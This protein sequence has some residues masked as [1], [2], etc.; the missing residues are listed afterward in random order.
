MPLMQSFQ[1]LAL[2]LLAGFTILAIPSFIQPPSAQQN[3]PTRAIILTEP[4]RPTSQVRSDRRVALVIGNSN[5][6]SISRLQNPLNDARDMTEVLGNLGFDRVISVYD[7]D[8]ESMFEAAATFHQELK[9]GSVGV[10]FYAGHGVQSDGENYLI[11]VD[12]N[13]QQELQLRTRTFPVSEI[14]NYIADA[15]NDVNIVILDAC[16]DNPFRSWGRSVS[17]GLAF[18]N[19]PKGVIIAYATAPGS[20]AADGNGNNGTY[21]A[22]LLKHIR[23]PDLSI[24]EL[25]KTVRGEVQNKTRNLQTPWESTSLTGS[26]S[27]NPS[28]ETIAVN[29]SPPASLQPY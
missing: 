11:P 12:A 13:I 29:S 15:G 8:L 24:E 20:V 18:T 22:A 21:T 17:R 6:E 9:K 7:A 19:A 27:F 16:R 23:T 5:Y 26:F 10:F 3:D 1:R 14:L 25:F 28:S 4:T 2:L